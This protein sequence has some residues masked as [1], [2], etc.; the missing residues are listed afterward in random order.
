MVEESSH[1][2]QLS[3]NHECKIGL[4]VNVRNNKETVLN[5]HR[6]NDGY[7]F[8]RQGHTTTYQK[9]IAGVIMRGDTRFNISFT[10][11][12]YFMY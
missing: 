2:K 9:T 3:L 12:F 5:G 4:T 10:K 6:R 7:G 8:R 1:V 11:S